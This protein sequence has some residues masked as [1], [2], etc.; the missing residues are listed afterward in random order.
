MFLKQ[1]IRDVCLNR[2]YNNIKMQKFVRG[3]I[4]ENVFKIYVQ[5][6]GLPAPL[7]LEMPMKRIIIRNLIPT[8]ADVAA[9]LQSRIFKLSRVHFNI[10]FKEKIL[11][12]NSTAPRTSISEPLWLNILERGYS[13]SSPGERV[14][15]LSSLASS[16]N[17]APNHQKLIKSYHYWVRNLRWEPHK[18]GLSV[19]ADER[20]IATYEHG[21]HMAWK[22]GDPLEFKN[23]ADLSIIIAGR[24]EAIYD[25]DLII[26][27]IDQRQIPFPLIDPPSVTA[28]VISYTISVRGSE[29]FRDGTIISRRRNNQFKVSGGN[30]PGYSGCGVFDPYNLSLVGMT[31]GSEEIG[32]M[33]DAN[34]GFCVDLNACKSNFPSQIIDHD[35]QNYLPSE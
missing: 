14:N 17:L 18:I 4:K 22:V 33:Q 2:S 34:T 12:N 27:T 11:A 25:F 32:V 8:V 5:Y 28:P 15:S 30:L 3:T 19:A 24:V 35:G 21:L 31:V 16:A 7:A 29:E 26:C 20:K 13:V 10:I 9:F 23:V 6:E 1:P